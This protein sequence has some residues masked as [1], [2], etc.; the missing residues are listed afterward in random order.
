MKELFEKFKHRIVLY[1]SC[2]CVVAGFTPERFI[3]ATT[4]KLDKEKDY[5]FR[6]LPKDAFVIDDYRDNRYRYVWANESDIIKGDA[7][8]YNSA[9]G[10]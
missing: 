4:C 6:V 2:E 5:S 3:L 9:A 10:K 1:P 7:K 8:N